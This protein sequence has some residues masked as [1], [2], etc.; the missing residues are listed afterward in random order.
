MAAVGDRD[1]EGKW[2][3]DVQDGSAVRWC[4]TPCCALLPTGTVAV[5][6]RH[7]ASSVDTIQACSHALLLET[8]LCQALPPGA[9]EGET[10]Q[11]LQRQLCGGEGPG[12]GAG[13]PDTPC[14]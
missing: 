4:G 1:W 2:D 8:L 10:V 13:C 3:P 14:A 11:K 5:A 6:L 12:R 9:V 7:G